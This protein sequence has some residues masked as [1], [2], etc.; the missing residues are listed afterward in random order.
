MV[1]DPEKLVLWAKFVL[2]LPLLYLG[3][4]LFPK[5]AILAIYLRVFTTPSYRVACWAL[6]ALLIANW[7]AF[8]ITTFMMCT[9]LEYLWNKAIIG[10]HCFNI[11]LFYR[12]SAF[13]NIVTDVVMLVLP[14]PAV[15]KLHTSRNI[16]IGL[17]ITFA[18]GSMFVFSFPSILC[19]KLISLPVACSHQSCDLRGFSITIQPSTLRG[20]RYI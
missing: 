13:P 15:W 14:L 18:A 20:Q 19:I 6:A 7:L 16:K 8:T 4:V 2:V 17:T 5:L 12:W 9:P 10:G 1:S 3:A 11:N